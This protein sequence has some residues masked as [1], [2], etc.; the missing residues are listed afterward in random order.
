[1]LKVRIINESQTDEFQHGAGPLELGRLPA[2][3][4]CRHFVIKD[5]YVSRSQLHIEELPS[6]QVRLKN[7]GVA[8]QLSDGTRIEREE[9]RLVPLPV[10]LSV[11]YT[12]IELLKLETWGDGTEFQ[13]LAPPVR[14]SG[15]RL[16]DA[17]QVAPLGA[18][19]SAEVLTN[20]FEALLHV[21]K[22]AV[23][24]A[25]FYQETAEA[26]VRL[27]GLDRG[28]VLLREGA[29]WEMVARCGS[30]SGSGDG[31]F[32]TRILERMLANERT[33]FQ[34]PRGMFQGQS[35]MG[36]DAV[37]AAPIFDADDRVVGAIY[38]SRD[39]LSRIA[40]SENETGI[41]PLEAQFVQLLAGAASAGLARLTSEMNA[42]RV[43]IQLE[44]VASPE[45]V[46]AMELH[47]DLLAG[48]RREITCLFCDLRGFSALSESVGPKQTYQLLSE[49]MDGL[50]E[51]IL[52][53]QGV[54]IDYYG[55]GIAAMWNAPL[56]QP[57]H[58]LLATRA[59]IELQ[60]RL[61]ELTPHWPREL[62]PVRLGVGIHTGFAHLGNA[63]SKRRIK[64]GPRGHTV[65]LTSRLESATKH[66][67]VSVLISRAVRDQL[68]SEAALPAR[69]LGSFRLAGMEEP[70]ELFQLQERDDDPGWD[71]Y[72]PRFEAALAH[73]EQGQWEQALQLVEE[74]Q[75]DAPAEAAR[76]RG[77]AP[78]ERLRAACRE[79]LAQ[80]AGAVP[81]VFEL[82]TK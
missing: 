58:A 53:Q 9:E 32:S 73:F 15:Q 78:T 10:R 27:I 50:T 23:G 62:G 68:P 82:G 43:R 6:G 3:P 38:G 12:R 77:D 71:A 24:S 60:R 39:A 7:L 74:L 67:G 70:V 2:D 69:R 8:G 63:G 1:M 59:A 36:V 40:G 33:Y 45:V 46:Q 49:L 55:D 52:H 81:P 54:I 56:D 21:Q 28:L 20:W 18:T 4:Q 61:P 5:L 80:P 19:P 16:G 13:T 30:G 25:E 79:R 72:C 57:D 22:S 42:A 31:E 34:G 29:G 11:G 14:H 66:L 75:A 64:Y 44:R 41:T 48:Q 51:V 17:E 47:P 26:V 35:L 37:V 65:N 76:W